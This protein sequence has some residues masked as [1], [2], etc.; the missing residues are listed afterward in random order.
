MNKKCKK[1][2]Q[3]K[4]LTQFGK[5][6]IR[7]DG[8]Q[9]SCK[10]CNRKYCKKHYKKNKQ[11]YFDKRARRQNEMKVWWQEYKANLKCSRCK[12]NHPVCLQFHHIDPSKKENSVSQLVANLVSKDKILKEIKKCI[13]LCANCHFKEHYSPLV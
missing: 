1:C 13:V 9:S 12:E 5:H 11:Y 8:Y 3:N 6:S 4:P 10:V 2:G 7:K